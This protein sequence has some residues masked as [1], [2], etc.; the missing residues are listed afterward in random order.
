MAKAMALN[1][2]AGLAGML[3]AGH[4]HMEGVDGA[5]LRNVEAAKGLAG[6]VRTSLGPNGMNKLV[7][8]HLEKIIVTSDCATIVKELEIQHPA[9]KMLELAAEMQEQ[10]CGDATNLTVS[11]A[12]E[13]LKMCEDLL[14]M[15][16]H[17][18]EIVMGYKKAYEFLEKALPELVTETIADARDAKELERVVTPV[19]AAKQFGYES[20]LA[21]LVV[22]A[23]M[24]T[25]GK[26]GKP[27]VNT[28]S[29]RIAKIMGGNV[30]QSE[31]IHGMVI[32][33][34]SEGAIQHAKAAKISV[35][36]C[37]I[38][39]SATEAK[40]T[41]LMKNADDLMTYNKSEEKKMDEIIK[42]IADTGTKVVIS[43]GTV[44]E[45]AMHFIERY[46]MLCVKIT[47]KW[48]LR[49]ICSATGST[50]LVRL[51]PATA[52]E[53]GFCDAV[54]VKEIGGR[55]VVVFAQGD[56]AAD[57]CRVST[58]LLRASTESVLN[59]LE[60]AVDDGVNC[61][62][63]CCLH[64]GLVPGAGATELELSRKIKAYGDTCP[65]LEQYAIRSFAKALE[66]VPRTLAENSG[67][68]PTDVL[69]A[70]YAAHASGKA[71][72]GVEITGEGNGTRETGKE[73]VDL[74]HTK[75]SA[76]RLAVDAA[77]TV[78]RVDQIIMSKPA[79]GGKLG[80]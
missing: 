15:G 79:G 7:I 25:M 58:I 32:M 13:L 68:E 14:R 5:T 63:T 59:D 26:G 37:G 35:F 33:R 78:L 28:D 31:V 11:F 75:E 38:E 10:E 48:E 56:N 49:R 50:A 72:V 77:V 62:R 46:G 53:L 65:G 47:S 64:G 61:I 6:I 40:G 24:G 2:A 9:A 52:E 34:G 17:T 22:E 69:A 42:S 18:S 80:I 1:S 67:Q 45:M 39:A 27:Q 55:K 23:C 8:N 20:F 36:A 41:V 21:P 74:L 29:V 12:G 16:L 71:G 66:F 51:G 43:G 4:K 76:F 30:H 57:G 70:L 19:L 44:S 54:D 3:K 60:R 73:I